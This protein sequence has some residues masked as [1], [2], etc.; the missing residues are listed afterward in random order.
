ME[1]PPGVYFNPGPEECVRD[2]LRPWME[3]EGEERGMGRDGVA[4]EEDIYARGPDELRRARPPGFARGFERRWF[5]LTHCVHVGGRARR[6]VATGGYWKVEQKTKDLEA[7]DDGGGWGKRR[8]Y[9]F[10]TGTGKKDKG[11]KTPWLMEEIAVDEDGG[12]GA[13]TGERSVPV[14]CKIYVSPRA[15]E[16]ERRAIFGEDGVPEDVDGKP[17]PVRVELSDHYFHAVAEALMNPGAVLGHQHDEDLAAPAPA[18]EQ[19]FLDDQLAVLGDLHCEA[20]LQGFLDDQPGVLGDHH[21]EEMLPPGVL[22]H[23]HGDVG[24]VGDGEAVLS[25]GVYGYHHG[26]GGSSSVPGPYYY[27]MEVQPSPPPPPPEFLDPYH[28]HGGSSCVLGPCGGHDAALHHPPAP[29]SFLGPG[30]GEEEIHTEKK[31]R[32]TYW[33]PAPVPKGMDAT[34]AGEFESEEPKPKTTSPLWEG[35]TG[36]V[37]TAS[38]STPGDEPPEVAFDAYQA[39]GEPQPGKDVAAAPPPELAFDAC[40]ADGEPPLPEDA[41]A[42]AALPPEL[43]FDAPQADGEPLPGGNAG[44][45]D[46]TQLS[47]GDDDAAGLSVQFD[48]E[49]SFNDDLPPPPPDFDVFPLEAF[50]GF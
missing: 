48:F 11:Q 49:T 24:D 43:A 2:Y 22:A 5:L 40:Q 18:P 32:M 35:S 27:G 13:G 9:G 14:L 45:M 42:L 1:A 30:Q 50:L 44:S 12:G 7:E 33:S 6:G 26:H 25:S 23:Q 34:M 10:Y 17:K 41:H 29:S 21:G 31:P 16:E 47:F 8:T 46:L 4:V 36:T 15:S 20:M 28:G 39:D 38:P 19:G 37:T 3:S